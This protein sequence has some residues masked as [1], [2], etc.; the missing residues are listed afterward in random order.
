MKPFWQSS[1][2]WLTLLAQVV[3][4]LAA[5]GVVQCPA[6]GCTPVAAVAVQGFGFL[7]MLLS[8]LGYAKARTDREVAATNPPALSEALK[9]YAE[10]HKAIGRDDPMGATVPKP[11]GAAIK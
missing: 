1:T 10:L 9:L 2:F 4:G 11:A 6:D 3:G 5:S 8:Y 7:T